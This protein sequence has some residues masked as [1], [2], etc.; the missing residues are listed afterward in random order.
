[1]DKGKA[2][3]AA[4]YEDYVA[5]EEEV[6]DL[7]Q[8]PFRA[9]DEGQQSHYFEDPSVPPDDEKVMNG[10]FDA[11]DDFLSS[12]DVDAM[13]NQHKG[14]ATTTTSASPAL[15]RVSRASSSSKAIAS[16]DSARLSTAQLKDKL[17]QTQAMKI[18]IADKILALISS[19]PPDFS[20]IP[21]LQKQ[22]E[23]LD[24][25]K[26]KLES[27]IKEREEEECN[28]PPPPSQPPSF[29]SPQQPRTMP[30]RTAYTGSS[31]SRSS[32][33]GDDDNDLLEIYDRA[34][35]YSSG[36]SNQFSASSSSSSSSS[37]FGHPANYS[38]SNTT[39][40][41]EDYEAE[42]MD[43]R[44]SNQQRINAGTSYGGEVVDDDFS[45]YNAPVD[46][47][48][49]PS[50]EENQYITASDDD[51]AH[52]AE[53]QQ[54]FDWE[55]KIHAANRNLFGNR[56]FRPNQREI[57][58]ATMAGRDCFVLMPTGGGKSLC[59]QLPAV[60]QDGVTIVISPLIS[61]IQDQ[62][63]SLTNLGIPAAHLGANTTQEDA[64]NIYAD[65]NSS[66]PVTKLLYVTPEKISHSGAFINTL[67]RLHRNNNLARIVVDEAH[68][69]SQWGH[70][71]REDYQ[72]LHVLRDSFPGVPWIALTATATRR[73]KQDI[74]N[75][76]HLS[77]DCLVF[78]MSFNRPNLI[79]E[80]RR[81]NKSS[82]EDIAQFIEEKYNGE[83]GIIYCF[84]R[85]EC[86]RITEK[87]RAHHLSIH[88]YHAGM[89]ADERARVQRD[90]SADKIKVIVATI[91]FGMGINKP[92]VRFVIHYT[93]PKSL[94]G[95]YQESGRAGR[96]GA[97]AHCVLYYTYADKARLENIMVKSM[98]SYAQLNQSRQNLFGVISFCENA[99]DCRRKLQL[100]YFGEKFDP[101]NC[102]ETCDNCRDAA[103]AQVIKR[104]VT[105]YVQ[106]VIRIVRAIGSGHTM[107][108]V[109]DLLRGAKDAKFTAKLKRSGHANVP[110]KGEGGDL[111]IQDIE[112]ILH[113]M[114]IESILKEQF[115]VQQ[116]YGTVIAYMQIGPN[117]ERVER[118][119]KIELSFVVGKKKAVKR[120]EAPKQTKAVRTAAGQIDPRDLL[121]EEIFMLRQQ[122]VSEANQ[123]NLMPYMVFTQTEMRNIADALPTT[124]KEFQAVGMGQE[125]VKKY[126]P[127]VIELVK[128]FLAQYPQMKP[129]G[130]VGSWVTKRKRAQGGDQD[131]DGSDDD[132]NPPPAV[133]T[134]RAAPAPTTQAAKRVRPTPAPTPAPA[135]V[136]GRA[137]PPSARGRGAAA[138]GRGVGSAPFLTNA[139]GRGG[140]AVR[141]GM[142]GGAAG[143]GI[144]PLVPV[145]LAK[146]QQQA[147]QR[148]SPL[149]A[150]RYKGGRGA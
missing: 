60:C 65:F 10:S 83:S 129:V 144:R 12:L 107:V 26:N 14:Q 82:L 52:L 31:S 94:E 28:G 35:G 78:R 93:L 44:G 85:S 62:V 113:Y 122:L 16:D 98:R 79:Y 116:P 59:Y 108:Y 138:A 21:E 38:N 18:E 53:W 32:Y 96:D 56:T 97:E 91:A 57:I 140:P 58:N 148:G 134:K 131:D 77:S 3:V 27:L 51:S 103:N 45:T 142:G 89:E 66:Q 141:G 15:T 33:D 149:N 95:Y 5:E 9:G 64:Q 112:R 76:L 36:S 74:L 99:I 47:A 127:R 120:V 135:P 147:A 104:D 61:L 145:P 105:K 137:A 40:Y 6:I 2:H 87:L 25:E 110:G 106:A 42:P 88:Y 92:D 75:H 136:F 86:E 128:T 29:S 34:V 126:G 39:D 37:S 109:R 70:E 84:S 130:S 49:A 111:T 132:F 54:K 43:N 41:S 11:D 90:W 67:G 69:V 119:Q 17:I 125:K 19:S 50:A 20:Q 115:E 55:R 73:V 114:V 30:T 80:V 63:M 123:V 81:K 101:V 8:E 22:S 71:F 7:T 143:R 124:L 4:D 102:H 1:M 100:Q 117:A 23:K 146:Q 24:L 48:E 139:V 68:C 150:F 72:K 121:N 13:V 118:G 46:G 133:G